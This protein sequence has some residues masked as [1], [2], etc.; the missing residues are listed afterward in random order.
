MLQRPGPGKREAVS[1]WAF[2]PAPSGLRLSS[3]DRPSRRTRKSVRPAE[4]AESQIEPWFA[5][6]DPTALATVQHGDGSAP[7]EN[8]AAEAVTDGS[9]ISIVQS[10][11]TRQ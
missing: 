4:E 1:P 7:E 2:R 5:P 3:N 10:S 8:D 9:A 11:L 6:R